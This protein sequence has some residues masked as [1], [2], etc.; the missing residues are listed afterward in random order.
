M[1]VK[2]ACNLHA[3]AAYIE[4]EENVMKSKILRVILAAAVLL[5][6][7]LSTASA[8]QAD[9]SASFVFVWVKT[10]DSVRIRTSNFPGG[11]LLDIR[12]G[13]YGTDAKDGIYVDTTNTGAGGAFEETYRIPA[14]LKGLD[15]IAMRFESKDGVVI[16]N[17]FANTSAGQATPTAVPTLQPTPQGTPISG[18]GPNLTITAVLKNQSISAR[19]NGLPANQIFRVRMGP[20]NDFGKNGIEVGQFNSGKG[21]SMDL[22]IPI[23]RTSV[24]VE[25]VSVRIDSDQGYYA[26]NA[27]KNV[28]TGSVQDTDAV[29]V[30]PSDTS[31]YYC[32]IV[33]VKPTSGTKLDKKSDFDAVWVVKNTGSKTW[34]TTAVDYK[35]L[36]GKEMH[37]GEDLYDLPKKVKPGET[38]KLIVD[39]RAPNAA[40]S[41]TAT[42]ALAQGSTI[43]CKMPVTI[44]AK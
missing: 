12:M 7:F 25:W 16:T 19:A 43:L 26:Y 36:S 38:V 15:R 24:D 41:F 32:E 4:L 29:V 40:G 34:E 10:D 9:G 27:F 22:L 30:N 11:K 20:L 6:G 3:C 37:T 18:G 33:S 28:S 44:T 31:G 8:V 35:Y 1:A 13:A 23:S 39:M 21:G 2:I 42:W 14:A 17:W 5:G